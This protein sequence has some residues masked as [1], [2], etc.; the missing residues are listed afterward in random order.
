VS[1]SAAD[2]SAER[3]DPAFE[4]LA[5][6]LAHELGTL[7]VQVSRHVVGAA[8][9]RGV[10]FDVALWMPDADGH[11][12][13]PRPKE[14]PA[15]V[16]ALVVGPQLPTTAE[17]LR[18]DAALVLD[19]DDYADKVKRIAHKAVKGAPHV[20]SVKLCLRASSSRDEEKRARGLSADPVVFVQLG[21][22]F[23][24]DIERVIFQL[25]LLQAPC[26]VVLQS[27]AHEGAKDR[28][29]RLANQQGFNAFLVAG[30]DGLLSAL[31]AVDLVVGRTSWVEQ[32]LFA[33]HQ[34]EVLH[35]GGEGVL[36]APR[37]DGRYATAEVEGVLQLGSLLER[38]LQ[39][40]G[41]IQANGVAHHAKHHDDARRFLD[42][43]GA[44]KP[45]PVALRASYGWE[46]IGPHAD[47]AAVQQSGS[48]DA[49][50]ASD[51]RGADPAER[52]ESALEELKARLSSGPA[53]DDANATDEGADGEGTSP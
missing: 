49:K 50:E 53:P 15:R 52:I 44:L 11:P 46:P 21:E 33:G 4:W 9:E 7:G 36:A 22:H 42:V 29:R 40:P 43:L 12:P 16:H 10:R 1:P 14:V 25:S 3:A 24:A 27:P 23:D 18:Y 30:D 35:L 8:P 39:D 19:D 31:G 28:A 17:L 20:Q 48:V 38:R 47:E 34:V 51:G 13:R 5:D 41:G 32:L 37:P 6:G 45:R 26:T 2:G